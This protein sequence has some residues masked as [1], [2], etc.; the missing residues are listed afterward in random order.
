MKSISELAQSIHEDQGNLT[1]RLKMLASF[2]L[3]VLEEGE[4]LRGKSA[5]V[6]KVLF[7]RFIPPTIDL[8]ARTN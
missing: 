6:P 4:R 7:D 8:A 2:G 5:L 1:K 3:V